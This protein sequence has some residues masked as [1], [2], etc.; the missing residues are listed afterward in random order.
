MKL[1]GTSFVEQCRP[2]RCRGR[3]IAVG[4]WLSLPLLQH[5]RTSSPTA[6]VLIAV[7]LL[8]ATS[9]ARAQRGPAATSPHLSP[10]ILSLACSPSAALEPPPTPLRIT[11]GQDS[12]VRRIYGPGDLVTMN[13]GM[14]NGIE[15][16]Q[17]YFVR[18]MQVDKRAP[19]SAASPATIRTTGWIKVWAIEEEMSL[20]TITHAC[21]TIEIGD[22]L[23]P[24]ALP[25]V[26]TV[27][28][29]RPKPER[30]NYGKVLVGTDRR[31]SFGKGDYLVIDRGSDFGIELGSQFVF[32]RDKKQAE[33]FLYHIGEGI[34]TEVKS[35]MTTVHVTLSLD[36]I[37]SGDYV[38]LRREPKKD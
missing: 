30:D 11:G 1:R 15:V 2:L 26:P 16:G 5:L 14:K 9:P 24:F 21:D 7:G 12:F 20:A 4:G 6:G 31:T 35:D 19:I 33:N 37:E 28:T 29:D 27:S 3:E 34:A 18:R 17:E 13:A 22:Y 10:E 25:V 8:A 38:A 32:Y 23:E 36:A